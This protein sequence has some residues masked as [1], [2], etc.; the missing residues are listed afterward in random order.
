MSATPSTGYKVK[1][2]S[3]KKTASGDALTVTNNK[4]T[5][6]AE[7]VTVS[8]EFEEAGQGGGELKTYSHIFST[9]PNTGNNISLS[10]IAWNIAAENLNN[11]NSGYAGVQFGT[12]SKVGSITL[13]SSSAWSYQ[14]ATNIKEIRVWINTGGGTITP[15][16]SIGGTNVASDG[17]TISKKSSLNDDYTKANKVTFKPSSS[18]TG[19]VVIKLEKKTAKEAAGYI[20]AIEIDAN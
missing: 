17:T 4:F 8:A 13:T 11:Y 15:T 16:V 19:V 18:L 1:S 10:N 9:K 14:S 3:A 5:M 12:S 2:V 6:P 20:C 7:A